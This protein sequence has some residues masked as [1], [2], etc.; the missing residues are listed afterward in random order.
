MPCHRRPVPWLRLREKRSCLLP[1]TWTVLQQHV[2]RHLSALRSLLLRRGAFLRSRLPCGFRYFSFHNMSG[3]RM[4]RDIPST[5]DHTNPSIRVPT[6][7]GR[8][9]L[10][11]IRPMDRTM[12]PSRSR[13]PST[14]GHTIRPSRTTG[15]ISSC[16]RMG[17]MHASISSPSRN[18]S[19]RSRIRDTSRRN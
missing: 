8:T 6:I 19:L 12:D 2:F 4:R 17:C 11:T 10:H 14:R 18:N 1:P 16:A 15:P 5:R 7:P 9:I 3:R 13:S